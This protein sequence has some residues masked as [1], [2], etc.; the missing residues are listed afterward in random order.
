[1][2]HFPA[3]NQ[4]YFGFGTGDGGVKQV[5]V[6]QLGHHVQ[7][8]HDHRLK[9]AALAFVNCYGIGK[10]QFSSGFKGIHGRSVIKEHI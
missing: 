4:D 7:H 2:H 8:W 10:L 1:M 6:A 9:F 5:A 3:A